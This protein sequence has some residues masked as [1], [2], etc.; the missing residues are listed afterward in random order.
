MV[1]AANEAA[2]ANDAEFRAAF[3]SYIEWGTRLAVENS[4]TNA[5]P[6]EN[7]PMPRWWWVCDA[8]PEARISALAD[9]EP[10]APPE[11]PAEGEPITFANV[12]TLFRK[13]DRNSMKFAFD[14]WSYADV[15]QHADEILMRVSNGSMP[16]DGAWPAEYVAAFERW[17]TA[18]KPE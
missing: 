11:L 1:A 5:K 7:M 9:T 10:E 18:G 14:L 17:I 13:Q 2:L 3:V 6:P 15:Q 12:K 16:C 8:T 4:Q